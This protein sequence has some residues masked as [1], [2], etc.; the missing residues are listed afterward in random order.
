MQVGGFFLFGQINDTPVGLCCNLLK[1][2]S[3]RQKT[4][5]FQTEIK[6]SF[7][8]VGVFFSKHYVF[9]ILCR[10]Y[11]MLNNCDVLDVALNHS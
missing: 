8:F 11:F 9:F 5:F 2:R 10:R 4:M 3:N 7:F 1:P 6:M